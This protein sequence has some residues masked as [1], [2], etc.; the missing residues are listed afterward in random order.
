[1]K[2]YI[3]D[4][5]AAVYKHTGVAPDIRS[6]VETD[7]TNKLIN[8][9]IFKNFNITSGNKLI[10]LLFTKKEC[11]DEAVW[12]YYTSEKI[13]TSKHLDINTYI[14]SELF[15]DQRTLLIFK[16]GNTEQTFQFSGSITNTQFILKDK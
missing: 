8:T 14:L 9:Y 11:R 3:D 12:L 15:P 16:N 10:P 6:K 1:M 2:I 7:S 4:L 13:D 5:E